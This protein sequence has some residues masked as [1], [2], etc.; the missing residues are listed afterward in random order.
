MI[1]YSW[2]A[3][4]PAWYLLNAQNKLMH[5]DYISIPFIYLFIAF[6]RFF[7]TAALH[8]LLGGSSFISV[9][10]SQPFNLYIDVHSIPTCYYHSPK[11]GW[12]LLISTFYELTIRSVCKPTSVCSNKSTTHWQQLCD[13]NLNP[14]MFLIWSPLVVF[15]VDNLGIKMAHPELLPARIRLIILE[16]LGG[17]PGNY[18]YCCL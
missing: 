6:Q 12:N 8:A 1:L 7:L 2:L 13:P 15:V 4:Q 5:I 14:P 10:H 11:C 9:S 18:L 16:K 17:D 3:Q